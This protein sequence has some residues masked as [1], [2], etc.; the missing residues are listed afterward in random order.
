MSTT[1]SSQSP[2]AGT[3]P[4]A[5]PASAAAFKL[6]LRPTPATAKPLLP[7][8]EATF[9]LALCNPSDADA[10][11][12]SL[13]ANPL[14][15]TL[16]PFT[17]AGQP[18]GR[19]TPMSARQH[20]GGD[21]ATKS[22]RRP[23]EEPVPAHQEL[24]V[25][26]ALWLFTSPYAPGRYRLEAEHR[27]APGPAGLLRSNSVA[28]EIVPARV[29][30]SAVGFSWLDRSVT[31]LSWLADTAA[32]GPWRLL[33][34][35]SRSRG[36]AYL[37]SGAH[38]LAEVP[39]G[40]RLAVAE[41]AEEALADGNGWVCVTAAAEAWAA[42]HS[43][44]SAKEPPQRFALPPG[45]H[46]AKPVP[47][48]PRFKDGALVLV[49]GGEHGAAPA[50]AGAAPSAAGLLAGVQVK[51]GQPPETPWTVPLAGRPVLAAVFARDRDAVTV[52]YITDDG[53]ES[54]LHRF[55]ATAAGR[56][57]EADREL[58]RSPHRPLVLRTITSAAGPPAF[59]LFESERAH[60]ERIGYVRIPVDGAPKEFATHAVPG[61]PEAPVKELDADQDGEGLLR[62]ALVTDTGALY[63][64]TLNRGVG[65]FVPRPTGKGAAAAAAPA[66]LA[67]PHAIGGPLPA[68]T[69]FHADGRLLIVGGAHSH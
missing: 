68:V 6:E 64:G 9:L 31:E 5:G 41:A 62:L 35:T 38:E 11:V 1:S 58:R 49:T 4:P 69:A 57:T 3:T 34:R 55:R 48:F 32:G 67:H 52:V 45:L 7:E 12:L 51:P 13:N 24:V 47:G 26:S 54:R 30:A 65:P 59:V 18:L 46:D 15:P 50:A 56:V 37:S 14:T 23:F 33:L 25:P 20:G 21:P 29:H 61:W 60:P 42:P 28:F 16:L 43:F 27:I 17:E 44:G 19:L 63:F 10:T 39:A 22:P 40:A 36:P 66:V 8:Q 53:Q 2:P